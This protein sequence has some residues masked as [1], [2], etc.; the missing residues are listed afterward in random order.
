MAKNNH[1]LTAYEA[2]LQARYESRLRFAMQMGL[3]AGMIAANSVFEM[4]AGRAKKFQTAYIE[5]VNQISN[6]IVDDAADD[7]ECVWAKATLDKK[8]L[9]IVGEENFVPFDERYENK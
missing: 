1:F 7:P 3:D 2:K 6:M 9:Q 4:G 8:L 5:T